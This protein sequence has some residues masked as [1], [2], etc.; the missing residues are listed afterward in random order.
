MKFIMN[1]CNTA[2]KE[3]N[4]N[5]VFGIHLKRYNNNI[6]EMNIDFCVGAR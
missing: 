4:N 3:Q 2:K 5:I 1:Y 6:F